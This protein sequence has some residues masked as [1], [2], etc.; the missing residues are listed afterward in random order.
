MNAMARREKIKGAE[1]LIDCCD[2]KYTFNHQTIYCWG[3]DFCEIKRNK[4]YYS[5]S[6]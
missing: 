3:K 4:K 1:K 5:W 2:M 6:C